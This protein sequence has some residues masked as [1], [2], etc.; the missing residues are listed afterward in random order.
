MA[1]CSACGSQV[2]LNA[3][4]CSGCGRPITALAVPNPPKKTRMWPWIIVALFVLIII[5]SILDTSSSKSA[6]SAS[7][8]TASSNLPASIKDDAD[9]LIYR[10]GK[11][12][13]D[14]T[15]AYDKPRPPIPTRIIDYKKQRV[16]AVFYPGGDA[17]VGSPPPYKWKLLPVPADPITK[18]PITLEEAI[19]RLPCWQQVTNERLPK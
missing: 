4:F 8:S 19:K 17:K 6:N 5:G 16:R 13:K 3:Q 11:P 12:S 14:D 2:A 18:Q 1:H 7:S 9:L 10:C 15:T